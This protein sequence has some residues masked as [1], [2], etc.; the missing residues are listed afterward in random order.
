MT[1][2]LHALTDARSPVRIGLID[3]GKFGCMFLAQI[4]CV[5]VSRFAVLCDRE[6]DRC[7]AALRETGWPADASDPSQLSDDAVRLLDECD[8]DM[9]V[10]AIGDPEAAIRHSLD[11][12]TRGVH[13]VSVAHANEPA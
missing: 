5:A 8:L 13:V 4:S 7:R 2:Q 1:D 6:I 3:A 10:E 12:F 9:V 11:A